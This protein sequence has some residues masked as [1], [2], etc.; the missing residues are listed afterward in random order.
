MYDN[1]QDME[2]IDI[3]PLLRESADTHRILAE[4]HGNVLTVDNPQ[5]LPLINANS[6]MLLLVLSNLF[7]NANRHTR[8]GEIL[9]RAVE[10]N[11]SVNVLVKDS[12]TGIEPDMLP[13]VF[14]RGI[15]DS[16]TG[17]GLSICK[18]AIEAHGG[19]I[20]IKSEQGFGTEVFFTLPI[21]KK[22]DMEEQGDE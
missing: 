17:L 7:T 10:K 14:K 3:S 16:G 1:S 20:S 2:P 22:P 21:H 4:R 11:D 15:S 18:T 13:H 12:G 6:D 8:N 9:I 5:S 19:D